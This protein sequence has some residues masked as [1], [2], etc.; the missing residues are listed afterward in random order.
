M[1]DNPLP[2][3]VMQE[4][5][6][7]QKVADFEDYC[8]NHA[9]EIAKHYKVHDDLHEDFAEWYH[10]YMS[11]NPE[12]FEPTFILLDS[13]Y[14]VDWWKDNSYLYDNFNSPYMEITK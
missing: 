8:K 13:D 5:D 11:Q 6:A 1:I 2:T 3:Q 4:M 12:L 7:I 14:I 9:I 10:D